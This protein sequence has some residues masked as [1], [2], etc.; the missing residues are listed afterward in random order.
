MTIQN[1]IKEYDNSP[2][3]KET[4]NFYEEGTDEE[5]YTTPFRVISN[6]AAIKGYVQRYI[7]VLP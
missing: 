6:C 3:P 1:L 5:L 2:T 4:M 7:I